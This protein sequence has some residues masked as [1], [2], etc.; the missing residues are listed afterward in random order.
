MGKDSHHVALHFTKFFVAFYDVL[1]SVWHYIALRF[2][3]Q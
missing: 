3:K 2:T 1:Q